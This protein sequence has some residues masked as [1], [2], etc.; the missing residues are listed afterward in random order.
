MRTAIVTG[1]SRGIGRG[2]A[3]LLDQNGYTVIYSGTKP[4]RPA[5]LPDEKS[6]FAA[7]ISDGTQRRALVAF[8]LEKYGRLDVLV[9]NAGIAPRVRRDILEMDEESFDE[10]LGVNLRGTTFM[11]QL[12]AKA[13][14]GGKEN[15]FGLCAAHHQYRQHV[16]VYGERQSRRVLHQQS[17]RRHGDQ[18]VC[19]EA[20]GGGNTGV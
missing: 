19:G 16:G 11:C 6:Y 10:V 13:M 1:S 15:A 14:L 2:I 3:D 9:N 17:G 18:A 8:A 12:A 7:D 20:G 5:D 4:E